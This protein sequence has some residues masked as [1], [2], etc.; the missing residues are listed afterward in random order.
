MSNQISAELPDHELVELLQ[1]IDTIRRKL[2]FLVLLTASEKWATS[3]LN[4]GRIPFTLK[5]LE[6]ASRETAIS[7]NPQLLVEAKKDLNIYNQLQALER[8]LVRL[9]EMVGDTRMQAGA[10]LYQFARV[11]YKMAKISASLNV[12]G[13]KSIVDDLG[14]LYANQGKTEQATTP[15]T[16][17]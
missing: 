17:V 11:A 7:P 4:E 5:A 15:L 10:E 1:A 9:T 12:P 14:L 6:Y 16:A 8:E 13:T 3:M 2:P